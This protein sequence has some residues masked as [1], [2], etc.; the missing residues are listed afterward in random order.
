MKAG[1][2]GVLGAAA[3]VDLQAAA[4]VS[5]SYGGGGSGCRGGCVG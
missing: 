3:A 2:M 1:G 4:M 5:S